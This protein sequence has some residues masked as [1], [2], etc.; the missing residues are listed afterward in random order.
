MKLLSLLVNTI[1]KVKRTAFEILPLN[2][3][4]LVP[5]YMCI[6][7]YQLFSYNFAGLLLGVGMRALKV[8]LLCACKSLGDPTWIYLFVRDKT[9]NITTDKCGTYVVNIR[10]LA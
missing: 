9:L 2:A 5:N 7:K 8:R 3:F 4:A 1:E 6:I 10:H